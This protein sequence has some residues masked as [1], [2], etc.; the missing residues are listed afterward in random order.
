MAVGAPIIAD[1]ANPAPTAANSEVMVRDL[2]ARIAR[3]VPTDRESEKLAARPVF[4]QGR[5]QRIHRW[6]RWRRLG[7]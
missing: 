6:G 2:V 5:K 7:I 4:Y 1:T 3:L